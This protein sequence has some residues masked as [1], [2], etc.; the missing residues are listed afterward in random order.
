MNQV[1]LRHPVPKVR[2]HQQRSV[3]VN[4]EEFGRLTYSTPQAALS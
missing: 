3:V 4:A 1:P 2:V